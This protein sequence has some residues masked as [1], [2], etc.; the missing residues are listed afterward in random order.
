M[1]RREELVMGRAA[2]LRHLTHALAEAPVGLT[3]EAA[4][5][6]RLIEPPIGSGLFLAMLARRGYPVL[7]V[8][9]WED[10]DG[11]LVVRFG[12]PFTPSLS[13]DRSRD[14]QD[15]LAREQVMT[16]IGRLLPQEYWGVY[17]AAIRRSLQELPA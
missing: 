15:R 11:T 3:P 1:P 17:E 4:G 13:Q 9:I 12:K 2:A 14:E 10:P 7:P 8:G 16:A 6:G 5:S